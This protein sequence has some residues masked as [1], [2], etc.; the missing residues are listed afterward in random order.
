MENIQMNKAKEAKARSAI[1]TS[2]LKQWFATRRIEFNE[3]IAKSPDFLRAWW[4]EHKDERPLLAA[5]ARD[6][7]SLCLWL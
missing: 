7:L 4:K 3:S 5:A 1:P 2:E 6:L